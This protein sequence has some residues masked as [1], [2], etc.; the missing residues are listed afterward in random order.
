MES[1]SIVEW[2]KNQR[3]SNK[4]I[5][6]FVSYELTKT[7]PHV[8]FVVEY[9][10]DKI[11]EDTIRMNGYKVYSTGKI[12]RKNEVLIA[13]RNEGDFT[14]IQKSVDK[15]PNS[16]DILSIGVSFNNRSIC[17]IGARIQIGVGNVEDYID[18]G[19][20]L[21]D[22]V[23]YTKLIK[24][25]FDSIIIAGDFNHGQI[26]EEYNDDF[27]YKDYLQEP[28]SYQKMKKMF[29][30]I[31]CKVYTPEGNNRSVFSWVGKAT[32]KKNG[33][34]NFYYIKED[35]LIISNN[36]SK[37]TIN[38]EWD[39]VNNEGRYADLNMYDYKS[40]VSGLPDHA[41]LLATISI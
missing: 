26:R 41:K 33:T 13:I 16:L 40:Q 15:I 23:D 19:K 36:L 28:C 27:L 20:Q 10:E 3:T 39:Y 25:N 18:R 24:N 22:L 34:N 4:P 30:E 37:N 14:N 29:K 17:L 8:I 1:I 11:F 2:N 5:D 32:D 12:Q 7:K 9:K 31:E 21:N 6:I 38:Y 35:H